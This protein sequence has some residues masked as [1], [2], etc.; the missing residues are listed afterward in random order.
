M[1]A[2]VAS[3]KVNSKKTINSITNPVVTNGCLIII[4]V[5]L[6]KEINETAARSKRKVEKILNRNK[7]IQAIKLINKHSVKILCLKFLNE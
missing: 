5:M 3:Q 6:V 7:P 2:I 4:L 1:M